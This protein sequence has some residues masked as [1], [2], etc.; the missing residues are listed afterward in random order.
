MVVG[1]LFNIDLIKRFMRKR[2]TYIFWR[3]SMVKCQACL[4]TETSDAGSSPHVAT[5]GFFN[6]VP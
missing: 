6:D 3:C 1:I 2:R 5:K 4:L